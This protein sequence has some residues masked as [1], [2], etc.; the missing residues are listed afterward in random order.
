MALFPLFFDVETDALEAE[1][2]LYP[3]LLRRLHMYNYLSY[4]II[5]VVFVSIIANLAVSSVFILTGSV[6][7]GKSSMLGL[8]SSTML[9]M[10]RITMW[11]LISRR[12][13]R[14]QPT[15][16]FFGTQPRVSNSIDPNWKLHPKYFRSRILVADSEAAMHLTRP[17]L[18]ANALLGSWRP[19]EVE[20][21]HT[22]EW[23]KP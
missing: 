13:E 9:L 15:V 16:Y 7:M 14:V 22:S 11:L 4:G 8:A 1:L 20:L 12:A 2:Q 5:W 6:T 10:P 19:A 18:L 21:A 23:R 3:D 17:Q